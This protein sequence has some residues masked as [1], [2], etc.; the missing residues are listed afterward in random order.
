VAT[1]NASGLATSLAAGST[2]IAASSGGVTGTTLLTVQPQPLVITTTSLS[3][4]TVNSSYSAG[5]AATGGTTPYTWSISSGVLPGGLALN[6]S[7]GS[8]TGNPTNAGTFNFTAQVS[9]SGNPAQ[10]TNKAFSIIISAPPSVVSIWSSSAAPASP[11]AGADNSVELGLRFKSDVNGTITGVRFYKS[12]ANTGTHVGTLWT[13][14]GTKLG[15]A[16][17]SGETASG[18]QQVTFTTPVAITSNTVYVASYHCTA[19]HYS[20]DDNYFSSSGVDN[21][22]LHAP[23]NTGPAGNGLFIYNANTTFPTKTFKAANYWVDVTF[24]PGP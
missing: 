19:G 21:S 23:V 20:E 12:A 15:S 4:G 24:K 14:A 7:T 18:W 10:T 13:S 16:T 8:I 2:T 3:G 9:D 1:I 22:P 5:I 17:F 11:D 6:T